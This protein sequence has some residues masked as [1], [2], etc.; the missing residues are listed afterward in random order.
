[1]AYQ[2]M[3]KN[4]EEARQLWEREMELLCKVGRGREREQEGKEREQG[5]KRT[6]G[7]VKGSCN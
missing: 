5:K 6:N 2:E 1:M 7:E 3:V 4:L